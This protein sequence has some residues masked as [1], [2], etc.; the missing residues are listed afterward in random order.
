MS[1]GLRGCRDGQGTGHEGRGQGGPG[2][3]GAGQEGTGHEDT[4]H[5]G[6]MVSGSKVEGSALGSIRDGARPQATVLP[7]DACTKVLEVF[8]TLVQ[9][10]GARILLLDFMK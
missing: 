3:E 8:D 1:G 9:H 10:Q 7:R 5:Q 4:G 2:Q 6:S